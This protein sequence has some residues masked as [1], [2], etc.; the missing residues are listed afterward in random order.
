MKKLIG[1][2]VS[3]LLSCTLALGIAAYC[4]SSNMPDYPMA[5]GNDNSTEKITGRWL[6]ET[7]AEQPETVT[8][9]GSS[10]LRTFEISTHPSNFFAGERAGFQVNLVGRG[11]C[12]SLIHAISI[13]ASGDAL[14][15]TKV[16]LITSPQSY[17][18][19]GIAPDL[20]M[21]NFSEQQYLALMRDD[22]IPQEM[23]LRFSQ[24]VDELLDEYAAATGSAR[25]VSASSL[26]AKHAESPFM[27]A[28]LSPYTLASS[29]LSELKDRAASRKLIGGFENG[30]AAVSAEA[31]DWAAELDKA[32][33]EGAEASS[34]NEFGILNDYYNTYIGR[35]LDVMED[36]DADLS[37]SVS[38]EYGDLRLLLDIC[39]LKGI[40]P[41]F[42]H[43]PL[44]GSWSDY[45]GFDAAER[46][47]YY[48]NVRSIV[49]EYDN[50]TLLDLTGGEYEEYYLCD[51]MHL[52]W[53][54]WL[55]VDKALVEYFE[56]G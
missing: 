18:E 42:V 39:E 48:E 28:V 33:A 51:I 1:G 14:S 6:V 9:Y 40:E 2:A 23:K 47:E 35:K 10:E 13:A 55:E 3:I 19:G 43:V 54:G 4:V 32:L 25:S 36:K 27:K 29:A 17:V 16:V 50:V 22:A 15:G 20:F 21:A 56:R 12:Q 11:S 53:K 30:S 5:L 24:R 31:I 38:E 44:H 8:I 26:L 7:A 45:T 34:N 46:E 37:Y 49:G 41:M 52:G